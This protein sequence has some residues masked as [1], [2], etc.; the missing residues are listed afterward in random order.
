METYFIT[1][2][3]AKNNTHEAR[4]MELVALLNGYSANTCW[5]EITS[6]VIF[7]SRLTAEEIAEDIKRK[8]NV[9]TDIVVIASTHRKDM[10]V[11]GTHNDSNIYRLVDFAKTI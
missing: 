7:E 11:V 5:E 3:L 2:R 4:Y 10:I 6:F 1:F 9:K 8:I